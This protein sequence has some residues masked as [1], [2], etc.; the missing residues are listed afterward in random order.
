M[1]RDAMRGKGRPSLGIN[2]WGR[3]WVQKDVQNYEP[4]KWLVHGTQSRGAESGT[5]LAVAF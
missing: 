4:R 5:Y 3:D 1:L 2:G